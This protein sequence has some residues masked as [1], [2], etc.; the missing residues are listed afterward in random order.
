MND[1]IAYDVVYARWFRRPTPM[2]ASGVTGGT[3]YL[4]L[5]QAGYPGLAFAGCA[6]IGSFSW[7]SYGS[8]G[9]KAQ[10]AHL[11]IDL[12]IAVDS[13]W[14][15]RIPREHQQI[16]KQATAITYCFRNRPLPDRWFPSSCR[17]N[18]D[19]SVHRSDCHER[20][21]PMPVSS[22]PP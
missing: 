6:T 1:E 10:P 8:S 4:Q 9:V 18:V 13:A 17:E 21:I 20:V 15:F 5:S 2:C 11:L 14:H 12:V 3:P 22:I 19:L 7:A 16:H